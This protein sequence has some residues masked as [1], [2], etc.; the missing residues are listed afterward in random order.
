VPGLS[1][2]TDLAWT[3]PSTVGSTDPDPT[4]SVATSGDPNDSTGGDDDDDDDDSDGDS[5]G[6]TGEPQPPPRAYD[7]DGDGLNDTDLSV[8]TCAD[9]PSTTCLVVDSDIT[10]TASVFLWNGTPECS[11]SLHGTPIATIGDHEGSALHEVHAAACAAVG[12]V[13]PPR[14]AVI[15]VDA[16]TVIASAIAPTAQIYGWIEVARDPAGLGHPILAPSYS[17]GAFPGGNWGT[18]CAYRPDLTPSPAC[19]GDGFVAT[20]VGAP[21]PYFREVGGTMQDLDGDGWEDLNLVFHQ[22]IASVS[23][24]TLANL[25]ATTFDVAAADEP[26]SPAWFHSGRNYGSHAAFTSDV[27]TNRLLLV[28]G[29]PVGTFADDLCNVSRFVAMLEAPAGQPGARGLAWS[30]YFGFSSSIFAT[31]DPQYVSDSSQDVARLADAVD[32]CIHRFE[33][34]RSTMD[35]EAV[36]VIDYFD[37]EAPIDYCLDEQFALYQDPAWTDE[38]AAAWYDCFEANVTAPG[39]WGMQVL[40]E[41]DG[42]GLTGAQ[43]LYVWGWTDTVLPGGEIIYLVEQLPGVGAFDLSDREPSELQLWALVGGLFEPRASAPIAGRP[44]VIAAPPRPD[45][46]QGAFSYAAELTLADRDRDGLD[47][48]QLDDDQWIGWD[49]VRGSMIVK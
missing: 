34:S 46:G 42:A 35:G 39:R 33:D 8:A 10:P 44:R 26:G 25:G 41:S 9:D 13:A 45:L 30:N 21:A 6:E 20:G 40:R 2:E 22:T 14:L 38:K 5:T 37:M 48:I 1:N 15:D 7:L 27:G 12:D 11:G 47:E 19:G 3:G 24:N 17:D 36:V 31:Y 18:V 43:E 4:G 49:N 28:G 16:G 32:G 23:I 29:V